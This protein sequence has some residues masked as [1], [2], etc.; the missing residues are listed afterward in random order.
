[1]ENDTYFD[2]ALTKFKEDNNIAIAVSDQIVSERLYG[3]E[4]V[5]LNQ[6][7]QV[8][9][10]YVLENNLDAVYLTESEDINNE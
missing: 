5:D 4:L 10:D 3:S 8:V 7:K 1:M 6:T 2:Q 9:N